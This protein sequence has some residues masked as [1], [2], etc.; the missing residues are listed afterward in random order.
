M[1][2]SQNYLSQSVIPPSMA[3]FAASLRD[4]SQSLEFLRV[5]P[6]DLH[7]AFFLPFS[8]EHGL[9][10][11]TS[12]WRWPRLQ[13]IELGS[14]SE[15]RD[16]DPGQ[17][18]L[19]PA[20][21]LIAAGKAAMTMPMLKAA[22]IEAA[23]GQYFYIGRELSNGVRDKGKTRM[24]LAGFDKCEEPKILAAWTPFLGAEA[25]LVEEKT[26]KPLPPMRIYEPLAKDE[27]GS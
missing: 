6:F 21:I 13:E 4:Y 19:S 8:E 23:P 12:K 26:C 16:W 15:M 3:K 10:D 5:Q 17:L 25:T 7:P 1:L 2:N 22:T 14:F 18:T 27:A 11:A 9:T 20:D 24:C